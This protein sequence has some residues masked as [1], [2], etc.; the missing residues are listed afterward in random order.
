MNKNRLVFNN[1]NTVNTSSTTSM[2]LFF[3]SLI[4]GK[5]YSNTSSLA[6]TKNASSKNL[7]STQLDNIRHVDFCDKVV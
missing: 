3:N 4:S 5:K 6:T 7:K 2:V 1:Q